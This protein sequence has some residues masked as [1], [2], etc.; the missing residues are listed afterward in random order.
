VKRYL[1]ND[2]EQEFFPVTVCQKK[3]IIK[4]PDPSSV[5]TYDCLENEPEFWILNDRS[6]TEVMYQKSDVSE[7]PLRKRGVERMPFVPT[8]LRPPY[9][10]IH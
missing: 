5:F 9:A 8:D 6:N 7:I 2:D 10:S 1:V 3:Q 4:I